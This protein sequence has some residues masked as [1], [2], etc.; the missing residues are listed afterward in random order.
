[1]IELIKLLEGDREQKHDIKKSVNDQANTNQFTK[2]LEEI[3]ITTDGLIMRG[4][5]VI[6]PET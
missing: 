1:M 2:I 5:R 6:I 3:T 4:N